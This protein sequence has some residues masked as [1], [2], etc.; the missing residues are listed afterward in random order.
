MSRCLITKLKEAATGGDLP[1]VG[2]LTIGAVLN[3]NAD[4]DS[5]T[6]ILRVVEGGS[7]IV[8]TTGNGYFAL[9]Y[10]GLEEPSQRLTRYVVE[11]SDTNQSL[12]FS[13]QGGY[14]I[15]IDNKYDLTRF[16]L[17]N[18]GTGVHT[19]FEFNIEDLEYCTNLTNIQC[20][21]PGTKITG[22]ISHLSRL[23]NL[24]GLAIVGGSPSANVTPITGDISSISNLTK[25]CSLPTGTSGNQLILYGT[26]VTGAIEDFVAGQVAN[27]R[28][29]S[30]SVGIRVRG[31]QYQMTF[32]G[33]TH[34]DV[35]TF[36]A[37]NRLIWEG[38]SRIFLKLGTSSYTSTDM[39]TIWAKG[40]TAEE[41]SAWETAGMTV[42]VIS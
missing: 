6:I 24:T 39:T 28:T 12:Y 18:N 33:T 20:L 26:N 36:T 7:A 40:A 5:Q 3:S 19:S 13:A 9:S 34:S 1:K 32:G 25:L 17:G 10:D 2:R 42:Y 31:W 23:V 30:P 8:T 14:E 22:D 27:G 21:Y 11:N 41:I 15:Y 16:S 29:N 35:G 4:S 37:Y 38:T